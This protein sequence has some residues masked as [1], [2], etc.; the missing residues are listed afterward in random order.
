MTNLIVNDKWL[1]KA[2]QEATGKKTFNTEDLA[3]ITELDW[4]EYRAEAGEPWGAVTDIEPLR[5]CKAL[6][7]LS[8]DG[9]HVSDLSPLAGCADLEEVWLVDSAVADLTPLSSCRKLRI[10][11]LYANHPL[12]DI[13][14]L[15]GLPAL[16]QLM[17]TDTQVKDISPLLDLPALQEVSLYD[18][19]RLEPGTEQYRVAAELLKRGVNVK[20]RDIGLVQEVVRKEEQTKPLSEDAPLADRLKALG[21]FDVLRVIEKHGLNG[22]GDDD[23]KKTP[24]HLAV[25]WSE[26]TDDPVADRLALVRTL[27]AEP[28]IEVDSLNRLEETPLNAYLKHN[29]KADVE[30]ARLLLDAGADPNTKSHWG[31]AALTGAIKGK[32]ADVVELLIERG[33]RW[34]LPHVMNTFA[35]NGLLERVRKGLAEGYDINTHNPED[36]DTLLHA[37]A[38]GRQTEIVRFLIEQGA[39]VHSRSDYQSTPLHDAN[40]A[41]IIRLLLEAG[42]E[43]N[44]MDKHGSTPLIQAVIGMDLDGVRL[45]L[46]AGADIHHRDKDGNTALH[47]CH[48]ENYRALECLKMVNFL[49]D[50]GA[51]PNALNDDKETPMDCYRHPDLRA[52]I[53][54]RGGKTGKTVLKHQAG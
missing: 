2:L 21:A 5:A 12:E 53:R 1:R 34:L 30:M 14:P 39:D 22:Q 20:H 26:F 24:L 6:K 40:N 36:G 51:A 25:R 32:C 35:Q 41:D 54:G 42:A 29:E 48:H 23:D 7:V 16:E 47:H 46:E 33:A 8:F 44:V 50:Q 38:F 4:S 43:V 10:L 11:N 15:R 17:L 45:L 9:N 13:S 49:I 27:L 3:E 52:T 28:G 18:L 19:F 37:A 31:D